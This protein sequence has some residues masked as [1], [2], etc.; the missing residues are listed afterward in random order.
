MRST[1]EL[2]T[3][4]NREK[5]RS[6]YRFLNSFSAKFVVIIVG[7]SRDVYSVYR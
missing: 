7:Y 2:F 6:V 3:S 4:I 5:I 1:F